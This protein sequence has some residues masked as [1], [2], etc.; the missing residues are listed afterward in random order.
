MNENTLTS[1]SEG[2]LENWPY[3]EMF[4]IE[5]WNLPQFFDVI[6]VEDDITTTRLIKAIARRTNNFARIKSFNTAEDAISHVET[7]K[8]RNWTAPDLAI[9]DVY[10]RGPK[11]GLAFCET[12]NSLYPETNIV[13]TSSVHPHLYAEKAKRLQARPLFLPKPFTIKQITSL[14]ERLN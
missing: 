12:I 2:K 8:R 9:V 13:V 11:D 7:L 14:F 4:D 5:K 6:V 1:N 10:L 3:D